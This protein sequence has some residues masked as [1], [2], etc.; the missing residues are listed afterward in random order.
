MFSQARVCSLL[1]GEGTSIQLT[2][3]GVTPILPNGRY[4]ILSNGGNP[5]PR[6]GDTLGYPQLGLDGLPPSANWMGVPRTGWGYPPS[7]LDGSVPIGT[8]WGYTLPIHWD[9]MGVSPLPSGH[10][11]AQQALAMQR[12]VCLLRSC[13]RTF[14]YF[15]ISKV[16]FPFYLHQS[17]WD[18]L[19]DDWYLLQ[20][21][22]LSAYKN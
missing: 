22:S 10:R 14:C 21:I 18:C 6:S 1:D 8:G 12:A 19:A 16:Y 20:M 5:D 7:G 3:G 4:L 2:R 17:Q 9:W 15:N 11:A 13:R